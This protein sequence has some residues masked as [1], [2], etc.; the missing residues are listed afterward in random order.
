MPIFK[1]LAATGGAKT[2]D[3][4]NAIVPTWCQKTK[5]V[6][7][8]HL[9]Q[10][11][12]GIQGLLV[13]MTLER[14]HGEAERDDSGHFLLESVDFIHTVGRL[15]ASNQDRDDDVTVLDLRKSFRQHGWCQGVRDRPQI[16]RNTSKEPGCC[17]LLNNAHSA[18]AMKAD[19]KQIHWIN[20]SSR[21]SR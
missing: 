12:P 4:A 11:L 2:G 8:P 9:N 15:S 7:L 3:A 6:D 20:M 1:K 18:S 17:F 14:E 5:R 21:L 16:V 10:R 19:G 13:P